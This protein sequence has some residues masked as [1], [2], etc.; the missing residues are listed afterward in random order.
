M[1]NNQYR[2]DTSSNLP[3]TDQALRNAGKRQVIVEYPS[4]NLGKPIV[5]EV[6]TGDRLFQLQVREKELGVNKE[7][8]T[9]DEEHAKYKAMCQVV[10]DFSNLSFDEVYNMLGQFEVMDLYMSIR[11]DSEAM[12][13]L[14]A[15]T[16]GKK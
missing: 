9:P 10:A 7:S 4:L 12:G 15:L 1:D 16:Q 3:S 8:N 14:L 6:A 5:V 2:V 13:K 11:G